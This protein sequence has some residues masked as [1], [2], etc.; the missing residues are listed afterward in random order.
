MKEILLGLE[1][2]NANGIVH[3][4]LS[5]SNILFD[6]DGNV[7][8]FNYGLYFMSN[9]GK[10]VSFPIGSP[11]YTAPEVFL[12]KD[13]TPSGPKVDIW[14]VGVILAELIL[15]KEIWCD[16]KL[17]QVIRKVLSLINCSGTVLEHLSNEHR[18]NDI[19]K[20]LPSTLKNFINLCLIPSPLNR[21]TP[22]QMIKHEF[23]KQDN[24]LIENAECGYHIDFLKRTTRKNINFEISKSKIN[25]INSINKI[26]SNKP[27]GIHDKNPNV[28]LSKRSLKEI[29]HLWQLAGGDIYCE[30]K[31]QGMIKTRPPTLSLPK[32]VIFILFLTHT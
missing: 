10:N 19:Y 27:V 20:N 31:K 9:N 17:N 15:N 21:L 26:C 24:S 5:P 2:L 32:Y 13:K 16:L 4:S 3:R 12:I 22:S 14:S 28:E 29:Y 30:L 1:Y 7:K 11:K 8:L 6:A 18:C 25:E 23:I